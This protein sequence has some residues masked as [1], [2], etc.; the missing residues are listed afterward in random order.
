MKSSPT[1]SIASLL[2]ESRIHCFA[3]RFMEGGDPWVKKTTR[4]C[5]WF[6]NPYKMLLLF[7]FD[8]VSRMQLSYTL[9][10]LAVGS[11]IKGFENTQPSLNNIVMT[12]F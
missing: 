9:K 6:K 12:F 8:Q 2:F 4:E 5:A 11:V 1:L 10:D 3:S 7:Q